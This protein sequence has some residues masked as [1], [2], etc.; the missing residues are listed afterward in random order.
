MREAACRPCDRESIGGSHRLRCVESHRGRSWNGGQSH[1]N[2]RSRTL[3][4]CR[5]IIPST[6]YRDGLR[7][8]IVMRDRVLGGLN[9]DRLVVRID[10]RHRGKGIGCR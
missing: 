7:A 6:G 10:G 2:G 8:V 4:A 3:I 1:R 9:R 5:R